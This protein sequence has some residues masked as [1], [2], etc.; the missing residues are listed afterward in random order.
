MLCPTFLPKS[1][2]K[3][4]HTLGKTRTRW[5][6]WRHRFNP[7][8]TGHYNM[9]DREITD[10]RKEDVIEPTP[11]QVFTRMHGECTCCKYDAPHPLTTLSD[12]S[13]KDW[14]GKKAKAREQCPLLDFNLLEKQLQKTLQDPI[15][16]M[17]QDVLDNN[18]VEKDLTK[19]LQALTLKEDADMQNSPDAQVTNPKYQKTITKQ[20]KKRMKHQCQHMK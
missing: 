16:D 11:K 17:S 14:D 10:F 6:N 4:R 9:Q 5:S 7:I 19:D 2:P 3:C 13:S 1:Q 15:Q 8:K 12:W 20:R 18:T